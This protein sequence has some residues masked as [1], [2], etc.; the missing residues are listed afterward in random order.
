MKPTKSWHFEI[1]TEMVKHTWGRGKHIMIFMCLDDRTRK[2]LHVFRTWSILMEVRNGDVKHYLMPSLNLNFCP[3][4]STLLLIY[5]KGLPYDVQLRPTKIIILLNLYFHVTN[6]SG[7]S[8]PIVRYPN[9]PSVEM[10][11][12]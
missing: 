1:S 11:V 9:M 12:R 8:N 2:C 3:T 7:A 4:I 6:V 5:L 10:A